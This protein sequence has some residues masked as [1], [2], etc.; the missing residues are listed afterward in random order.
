MSNALRKLDQ[1]AE[2]WLLLVFYTMLV[3]T[4]FIEVLRREVLSYSSIWGEE[5]V[6]YSF[7]YLAW[8]GAA[9]AVRQRGH[10]RIDV[11][12][13]YVG[14]RVKAALYLFGDAVMFGVALIA[15]YWSFE[16]V[17]V[18]AKFGSVTHGLRVSQVWFLSAVPLGFALVILR[19]VQSF[20]RDFTDLRH[21]RPVYEGDKLFD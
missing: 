1:N 10:I 14:P 21:G 16:T 4:M 9:A 20:I 5:I 13:Q 18:S 3:V 11:L 15:F 2:R 12:M 19:L 6:R 17:L 7:I 8:I